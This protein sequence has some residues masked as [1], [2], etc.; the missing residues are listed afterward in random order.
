MLFGE[1]EYF[2]NYNF[3]EVD[4]FELLSYLYYIFPTLCK[5]YTI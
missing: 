4:F 1:R 5:P 3:R 2:K